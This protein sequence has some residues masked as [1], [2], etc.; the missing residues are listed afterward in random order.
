LFHFGTRCVLANA[1][2]AFIFLQIHAVAL[3]NS[4]EAHMFFFEILRTAKQ[5]EDKKMKNAINLWRRHPVDELFSLHRGLD[6]LFGVEWPSLA[7]GTD[8]TDWKPQAA[9]SEDDRAYHV[10]LDIP[11]VDKESIKIDFQENMLKVSG[12]RKEEKVTDKETSHLSE[13]FFGS[14]TRTFAFPQHVNGE[15]ISARYSNGVLTIDLDK[16]AKAQSRQIAIQ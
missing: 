9:V 2:I 11:G 13:V 1:K 12:E 15:K 8:D 14:F 5:K 3:A 16:D 7:G 4:N 10:K 6:N